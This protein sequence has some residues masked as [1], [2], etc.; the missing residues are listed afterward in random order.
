MADLPGSVLF[1]CTHNMVRSPMAEAMMKARFPGTVFV[2]SCGIHPGHLDSFTVRVMEEVGL[3]VSRHEPKDFNDL[4]DG[5][6]DLVVC[7]SEESHAMAGEFV[8]G[9]SMELEYWP[10]YDAALTSEN[11]QF[12]L[13]AY[14]MVRDAIAAEL[15]ARFGGPGPVPPGA[16]G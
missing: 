16:P 8:L 6:F 4:L 15:D 9:K 1:A 7:F 10:I 13:D 12:R 3:D 14:R 2:D 11:Q 5:S